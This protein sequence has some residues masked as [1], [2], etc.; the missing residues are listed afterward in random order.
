MGFDGWL[1]FAKRWVA[2]VFGQWIFRF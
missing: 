2:A 1:N